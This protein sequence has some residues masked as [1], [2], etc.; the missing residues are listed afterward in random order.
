MA[1]ADLFRFKAARTDGLYESGGPIRF[2]ARAMSR[3]GSV[4]QQIAVTSREIALALTR[5]LGVADSRLRIVREIGKGL[6]SQSQIEE[7]VHLDQSVVSRILARLVSE[8]L[9][10]KSPS[11]ADGRV[12][13]YWLTA[14]GRSLLRLMSV[15][16]SELEAEL[17]KELPDEARAVL[18]AALQQLVDRAAEINARSSERNE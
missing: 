4:L 18:A 7:A 12:I 17:L 2:K 1:E 15:K 6:L 14:A 11:P 9:V 13:V 16:E 3:G 8:E 5:Q 10:G